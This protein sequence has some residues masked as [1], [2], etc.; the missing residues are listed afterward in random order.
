[1][2]LIPRSSFFL[3]LDAKL[4]FF[5]LTS[6]IQSSDYLLFNDQI[7]QLEKDWLILHSIILYHVLSISKRLYCKRL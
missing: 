3:A 5:S 4:I 1:M 2:K 7:I 6:I